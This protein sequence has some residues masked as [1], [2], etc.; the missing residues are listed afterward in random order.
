[1]MQVEN[2][3]HL[4]KTLTSKGSIS[5]HDLYIQTGAVPVPAISFLQLRVL[6]ASIS[7]GR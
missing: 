6:A 1:M 7:R 3:I 2:R 5:V 4:I